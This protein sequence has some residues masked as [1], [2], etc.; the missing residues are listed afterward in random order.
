MGDVVRTTPLVERIKSRWP[1]A[2]LTWVTESPSLPLLN[3]IKDIN[4]LHAVDRITPSDLPPYNWAINAD[5][6][7]EACLFLS[8]VSSSIKKGYLWKAGTY[9]PADSDAE[10]AYQ[11]S[12][13]DDLK[14]KR[15]LQTYQQT[16]F[17]M[18]GLGAFNGEE[19]QLPYVSHGRGEGIALNPEVG[20]KWPTKKWEHW[21]A[22]AREFSDQKISW[23]KTFPDVRQYIEWIDGH[24]L[25]VTSDSLGMHLA[26]ALKKSVVAIFG[27][28]AQQEVELYGR[29]KKLYVEQLFCAPCY[30]AVCPYHH[31][32]MTQLPVKMVAGHI[33]TLLSPHH[34]AP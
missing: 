5:E 31:E 9:A 20:Q 18:S 30:K 26:I 25:T 17:Q 2:R 22:L 19:M 24:A 33:R 8:Q 1:N 28:T 21:E 14:F 32:C 27:P 13:D 7:R 34:D 6:Q 4:V 29:G 15:N 23:Q 16:L 10:Y 11:L 3:G 12:K